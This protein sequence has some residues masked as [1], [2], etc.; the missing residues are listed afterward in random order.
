MWFHIILLNSTSILRTNFYGTTFMFLSLSLRSFY[1]LS[2]VQRDQR[3]HS[4][5]G[6]DT[7]NSQTLRTPHGSRPH[8]HNRSLALCVHGPVCWK[9]TPGL[10]STYEVTPRVEPKHKLGSLGHER[11][12][13]K[14]T[15]TY[16]VLLGCP[17]RTMPSPVLLMSHMNFGEHPSKTREATV[18]I[19]VSGSSR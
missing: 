7:D 19:V 15:H 12:G 10:Q 3:T 4:A 6:R 16:L 8:G 2:L 18:K 5:V 17:P 11:H 9:S 14:T 13:Q 1:Q